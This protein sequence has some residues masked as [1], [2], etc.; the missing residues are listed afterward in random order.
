LP[1]KCGRKDI[2]Y[3]KQTE[4]NKEGF[5]KAL[6]LLGEKTN[7]NALPL[8]LLFSCLVYPYTFSNIVF[9]VF[10]HSTIEIFLG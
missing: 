8:S 4:R 1:S 7:T 5:A 2:A 10:G 3:F 9:L 6:D